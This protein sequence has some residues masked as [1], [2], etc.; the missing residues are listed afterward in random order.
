[1]ARRSTQVS[2]ELVERRR[3]DDDRLAAGLLLVLSRIRFEQTHR[4]TV[5]RPHTASDDE[6]AEGVLLV[7]RAINAHVN[8]DSPI[9]LQGAAR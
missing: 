6:A 1:M 7:L 3:R 4:P 8:G 5:H 2:A 9:P